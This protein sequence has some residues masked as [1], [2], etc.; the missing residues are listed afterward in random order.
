M[1][2]NDIKD[3]LEAA[4]YTVAEQNEYSVTYRKH[5]VRD[6]SYNEAYL[7]FGLAK[8]EFDRYN[9]NDVLLAHDA[10]PITPANARNILAHIR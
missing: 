1:D 10:F 9:V 4:D 7:D 3:A 2:I 6:N 5:I 8:V